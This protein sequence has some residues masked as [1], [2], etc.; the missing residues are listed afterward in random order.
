MQV[1]GSKPAV[2]IEKNSREM[3]LWTFYD[4]IIN[5]EKKIFFINVKFIK[6]VINIKLKS[7]IKLK[8]LVNFKFLQ[9]TQI[10]KNLMILLL[11]M[12]S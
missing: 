12:L 2:D 1:R 8:L 3:L 4:G 5:N 9:K 11:I 10:T 7:F 6:N